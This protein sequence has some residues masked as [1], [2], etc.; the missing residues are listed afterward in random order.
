[1]AILVIGLAN[2]LVA[3][4]WVKR[5]REEFTFQRDTIGATI[6]HDWGFGRWLLADQLVC[7]TQ[8]YA[9]HW[10]LAA[11]LGTSATGIF[12]ACASIAALA[13][14]LLQGVGN[15]LSPRFADAVARGDRQE[16]ISLYRRSSLLLASAVT[17]FAF[18]ASIFGEQL[19]WL[20]YHDPAYSSYGVVVGILAFRMAF[21]IPAIAAHH[22]VVAMERPR[23]SAAATVMGL[24]A[25][26]LIAIPL[27]QMMGIVGA[28]I[29]VF[30][31]TGCECLSLLIIFAR[32]M[33]NWR[34]TDEHRDS[35][36]TNT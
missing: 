27:I 19:L 33:R 11:M 17:L 3:S 23:Y 28:A 2:G 10:I 9:M 26:L 12:A 25:T 5:R 24:A 22:A 36:E 7:F 6:R 30:V 16:T 8:L 1:M 15:Y 35:A 13:S 34:W 31:G 20:L 4:L 29:A 21:G 18:V 14:P 32:C